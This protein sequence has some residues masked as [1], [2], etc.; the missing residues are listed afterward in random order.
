MY[1]N[2]YE[3]LEI[4]KKLDCNIWEV[5]LQNES[6]TTDK[7]VNVIRDQMLET[8][9]VM[10]N[11]AAFAQENY[12]KSISGL[13]GGDAKKVNEYRKANK[14]IC[15]DSVNIAISRALSSSEVNASMGRIVAAP[16]AGSC[17]ILPAAI[18]TAGEK[19][20]ASEEQ[21]VNGLLTA[22]G[23]GQIIAKNATLSGAEGG[24]QAECGSASAMAAAALV[25]M[26][27]GSPAAAF[28]AAT[29]AISNILGL[30]CDPV[31][32]LVEVPCANRNAMGVV[33]AM[34][35]ADM[36]LAGVTSII[37]FDEIVEAMY[38]VGRLMPVA[39]KETALG[40]IAATPTALRLK[41]EIFNK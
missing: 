5:V 41:S 2:A 40:G 37:P 33:N 39:F 6:K 32:G 35:C 29:I 28:H 27:G 20:D 19:I 1:R 17:G 4:T 7:P 13:I 34:L 21:L 18:I 9:R 14:T 16:T 11:S 22:S 38:K 10:Q 30:V 36:A 8:F 15:G 3:L 26:Y 25:E 23:I 12:I 31:A 24:C